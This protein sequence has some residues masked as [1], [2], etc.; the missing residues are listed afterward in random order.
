MALPKWMQGYFTSKSR[1]YNTNEKIEDRTRLF[2]SALPKVVTHVTSINAKL[3]LEIDN[4]GKGL[5][6]QNLSTQTVINGIPETNNTQ[7]LPQLSIGLSV[8]LLV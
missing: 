8:D 2:Y 4:R 7:Q 6:T 5:I 1:K 3:T